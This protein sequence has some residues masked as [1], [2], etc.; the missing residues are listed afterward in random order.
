MKD[1]TQFYSRVRLLLAGVIKKGYL[2]QKAW[3]CKPGEDLNEIEFEAGKPHKQEP[4]C[5]NM[6]HV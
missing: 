4:R 6:Q 1:T 3:A 5:Q 2:Q